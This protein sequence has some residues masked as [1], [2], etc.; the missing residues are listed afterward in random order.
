M[1]GV[2]AEVALGATF[3]SPS[4]RAPGPH[5]PLVG[6][7]DPTGYAND[8]AIAWLRAAGFRITRRSLSTVS[9]RGPPQL[10]EHA[11]SCTL[12]Y[13]LARPASAVHDIVITSV[14]GGSLVLPPAIA[15]VIESVH[16]Q[17]PRAHL[18]P[19]SAKPPHVP[20]FHLDVMADVPKLLGA[21][22][23]HNNKHF[24]D[25]IG[26]A[27][28]DSG[29]ARS[30]PFFKAIGVAGFD[31]VLADV[32][33]TSSLET[34]RSGHG[35]GQCAN[36][37]A[38]APKMSFTGIKLENDLDPSLDA[39]LLEGFQ[40]IT[41]LFPLPQVV[42]CSQMLF[43]DV[44]VGEWPV[45]P[46]VCSTL[47]TCINELLTTWQI[48]V[49]AS[50]GNGQ[51]AFPGCMPGVI[52]AGGAYV[53]A[54]RTLAASRFASAY[55]STLYPGRSVPDVCG[56]VGQPS[57][58]DVTKAPYIML[59]VPAGSDIDTS[60]APVDGTKKSDGWASFSG[61]SAAAPQIAGV[62]AILLQKKKLTPNQL[63]AALIASATDVTSGSTNLTTGGAVAKKG[64]DIATGAGL[65][66]AQ[67]AWNRV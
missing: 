47:A 56:L 6:Y 67:A 21:Q 40:T 49:V 29:F 64:A 60:Y 8:A 27:M 52:S 63:K 11:F 48:A 23:L 34:D 39:T 35:T 7:V 25:G 30:H 2:P 16:P 44:S 45:L 50:A 14:L 65:V 61:T 4:H 54:D 5:P 20:A 18:G 37:F 66:N 10:F 36:L 28:I 59:P 17:P 55:V 1:P 22:S 19:V 41:D 33:S 38:M 57:P 42:S 31:V 53:S 32:A 15:P 3:R 12:S 9:F 43:P 46:P 51:Y 13:M 62:C 24:G 26:V 58:I